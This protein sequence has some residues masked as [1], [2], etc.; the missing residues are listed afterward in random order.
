MRSASTYHAVTLDHSA[1]R[2][3][4][5][6][7]NRNQHQ[8]AFNYCRTFASIIEWSSKLK[9]AL[10]VIAG[11]FFSKVLRHRFVFNSVMSL[12]NDGRGGINL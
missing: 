1:R 10:D 7:E 8:P 5:G 4:E 6:Q 9:P 3:S 2:I 12:A 11:S